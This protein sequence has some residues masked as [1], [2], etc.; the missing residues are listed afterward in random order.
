MPV[1]AIYL[2]IWVLLGLLLGALAGIMTKGDPPY[3]LGVDIA[4][5]VLTTVGIGY[6]DYIILPLMGY[7]GPLRFAAAV[8]EPLLS[9]ALVL[10][11]LRVI[12]RRTSRKE[13]RQS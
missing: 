9:A 7:E 11:L 8:V 6:L 4:A 10:W 1:L 13:T 3:G 5:S 12:R 2:I